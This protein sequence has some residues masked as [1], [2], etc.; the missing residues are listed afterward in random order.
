L[1]A[2]REA[3]MS[4]LATAVFCPDLHKYELELTSD[5]EIIMWYPLATDGEDAEG[6]AR[7]AYP[8]FKMTGCR[9][10]ER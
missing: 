8:G 1:E 4:N 5:N 7:R 2:A 6:Q 9:E 3:Q 10:V